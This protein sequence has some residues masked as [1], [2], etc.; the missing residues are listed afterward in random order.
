[1]SQKFRFLFLAAMPLLML[2]S[3][4][5]EGHHRNENKLV[6]LNASLNAGDTYKLNLSQYGDSDDIAA[7]SKQAASYLVSEINTDAATGSYVY[8]FSKAGTP[9]TGGNVTEQVILKITE[10][11]G[12]CGHDESTTIT[13]NFTI[14]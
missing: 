14:L 2:L 10:P 5:K 1:M 13:I 7:I 4:K 9:K 3:C 12:R 6:T 8:T 11:E